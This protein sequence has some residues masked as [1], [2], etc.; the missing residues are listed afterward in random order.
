MP[1]SKAVLLSLLLHAA[2][3]GGA[4]AWGWRGP[5]ARR[6]EPL[7]VAWK[8]VSLLPVAFEAPADGG[9]VPVLPSGPDPEPPDEG[10]VSP[11]PG[12]LT[13]VSVEVGQP[14]AQ[15]EDQGEA[16]RPRR[17]VRR[18]P[19][20]GRPSGIVDPRRCPPPV[21]PEQA[22]ARGLEGTLEVEVEVGPDGRIREVRLIR[23]SGS[24]LL[25]AEALDWI[26]RRW[27]PF[28]GGPEPWRFRCP[29]RF[30][31]AEP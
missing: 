27:G 26:R 6:E 31:L 4:A 14:E 7:T 24:A 25:D 28:A 18:P 15:R 5:G 9:G 2:L 23:P 20:P 29:I 11:E 10:P 17:P 22:L 1:V 13:A 30:S 19:V 12:F 8:G 21:Y 3:I 16:W